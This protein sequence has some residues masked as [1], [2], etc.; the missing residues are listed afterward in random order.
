MSAATA[1][2]T[3]DSRNGNAFQ[4]PVAAATKLLAGVMWALDGSNRLVNASDA[5]AR[6][7]VG[8]GW[9]EVDN[10]S[11]S[12]GDLNADVHTGLYCLANGTSA[13]TDAHIGRLVYVEDN[14]TVQST[15]GTN[16]VVA[17]ILRKVDTAGAWVEFGKH[18]REPATIFAAGIHTWAGG[19]ATTDSITVTGLETTDIVLVT[20]VLANSTQYLVKAVNDAGNDQIDITLSANGANDTCKLSYLVLRPTL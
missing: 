2:Q 16:G 20:L 4:F 9:E 19:A 13:L 8:V 12:A 17:G 11:G 6:R 10:S 15:P 14:Q 1:S 5:A 18:V 7:V 3:L